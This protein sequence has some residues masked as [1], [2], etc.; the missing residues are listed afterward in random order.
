MVMKIHRP[1]MTGKPQSI[2]LVDSRDGLPCPLAALWLDHLSHQSRPNTLISYARDV[3]NLYLWTEKANI[4]LLER[5][6][7]LSGFTGAEIS[8]LVGALSTGAHG[9]QLSPVTLTR[10]LMAVS[11][12]I[13][14]QM[15][16]YLDRAVIDDQ[17][18]LK[19]T[20]RL[21][22][23]KRH[24]AKR[25]LSRVE[26]ESHTKKTM[27]LSQDALKCIFDALHP[28]SADNPFKTYTIKLRNYCI[29]RLL[30]EAWLRRSELV[31]LELEDVDL[32]S[33]PTVKVKYSGGININDRLDNAAVKTKGRII[34][35]S[36]DL[37]YYLAEYIDFHRANKPIHSG[38]STALFLNS[39]D[40]KRLTSSSISRL[41]N[42]LPEKITSLKKITPQ[43][44][45]HMFRATGA[46]L[47]MRKATNSPVSNSELINKG[48]IH[49]MM[50]YLGGWS[51]KSSMPQRYAQ[52]AVI[53][54][55]NRKIL[56]R[57]SDED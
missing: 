27:P 56:D 17:R 6:S 4:C 30:T 41:A 51:A 32:G 16:R 22:R 44:N 3:A 19:G 45:A 2:L 1:K 42:S 8:S 11:N 20:K 14:F 29:F 18:F 35:I 9:Q 28:D 7:N 12:F 50:V 25:S 49:D 10:R 43:I 36:K 13:E 37:A 47:F 54:N 23:I 26:A 5:F 48:A 24:I 52:R 33:M 15:E 40:G 39:K 53:E 21:S 34:P 31:L 55:I 38:V 46:T 57:Y